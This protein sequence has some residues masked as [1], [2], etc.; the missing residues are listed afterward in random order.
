MYFQIKAAEQAFRAEQGHKF[1]YHHCWVI[2]RD[3]PK[4]AE[5][6]EKEKEKEQKK[7]N[8]RSRRVSDHDEDEVEEEEERPIGRK[9]AKQQRREQRAANAYQEEAIE[10]ERKALALD[11]ECTESLKNIAKTR[12]LSLEHDMKVR[13]DEERARDMKIMSMDLSTMDEGQRKYFQHLKQEV[14]R[15]MGIE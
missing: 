4:W 12:A 10:L 1:I 11:E 13:E 14:L 9:R 2:L 8:K 7:K 6:M 3:L 15:K 5:H